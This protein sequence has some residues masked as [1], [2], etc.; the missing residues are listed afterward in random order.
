[1]R[2]LPHS[3]DLFL[4][5]FDPWYDDANRKRRG[6]ESTFPDVIQGESL[7]GL[8]QAEANWLPEEFQKDVMNTI[9]RMVDAARGD[10]PS[11]LSVADDINL[12][13]INAFDCY[14][15]RDR[16]HEVIERSDPSD[17]GNDYI[18]TCCEFGAALSYV[19]RAAQPRLIWR[20]DWPYWDSSL[21][22]PKTGTAITVFHWGIKKMSEYGV[23]DGYTAKTKACLRFLADERRI[24]EL[25]NK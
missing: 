25:K 2:T 7:E 11:Y 16:I 24:S 4:Q 13:W 10:W 3:H 5:F 18:V 1:M 14:Y 19:L 21:L 23:D 9:D 8:S 12:R 22:D 6:F 20:L 15:D 17:Y